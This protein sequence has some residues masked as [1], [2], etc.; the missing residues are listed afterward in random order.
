MR[1]TAQVR[2]IEDGRFAFYSEWLHSVVR[3]LAPLAPAKFPAARLAKLVV[4]P[5]SASEA[6]A[7]LKLLLELGLF[8]RAED[9]VYVQRDP[10]VGGSGAPVRKPAIIH[11]QRA[12]PDLARQ[13]WDHFGENEIAMRTATLALSESATAAVKGELKSCLERIVALAQSDSGKPSFRFRP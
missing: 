10:F 12:M 5:P 9:G 3:E 7:S 11:F 2:Q 6:A 13:A 8:S 1:R 4:P